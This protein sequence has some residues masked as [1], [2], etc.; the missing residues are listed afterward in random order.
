M[1]KDFWTKPKLS[2][3]DKEIIPNQTIHFSISFGSSRGLDLANLPRQIL[4]LFYRIFWQIHYILDSINSPAFLF[5]A[6]LI[7]KKYICVLHSTQVKGKPMRSPWYNHNINLE[8]YWLWGRY[9]DYTL[10]C[11]VWRI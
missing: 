9:Y 10:E 3:S 7:G 2:S 6:F 5:E 11:W 4:T 1:F 8:F